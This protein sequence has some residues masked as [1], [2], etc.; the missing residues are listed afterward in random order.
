MVM[1]VMGSDLADPVVAG[2]GDEEVAEGVHR[3]AR[4]CVELGGGGQDAAAEVHRLA[5]ARESMIMLPS[6]LTS[7]IRLLPV[8]AM[9]RLPEASTATPVAR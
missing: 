4:G 8:S 7:Q 1:V 5:A 9:K 3:D 2:I 6:R